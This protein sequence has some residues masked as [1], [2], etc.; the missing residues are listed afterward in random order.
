MPSASMSLATVTVN[1]TPSASSGNYEGRHLSVAPQSPRVTFQCDPGADRGAEHAFDD[2]FGCEMKLNVA[3]RV[4]VLEQEPELGST[5]RSRRQ[6]PWFLQENEISDTRYRKA[7][8]SWK[9]LF[10]RGLGKNRW[11]S[12]AP[13]PVLPR[14]ASMYLARTCLVPVSYLPCGSRFHMGGT[15]QAPRQVH[16]GYTVE[17]S[18]QYGGSVSVPPFARPRGRPASLLQPIRLQGFSAGV[19][20]GTGLQQAPL[21]GAGTACPGTVGLELQDKLSPPRP[22]EPLHW[23][24][25]QPWNGKLL[26]RNDLWHISRSSCFPPEPKVVGFDPRLA[27]HLIPEL[28]HETEIA[29]AVV[30]RA[31]SAQGIGGAVSVSTRKWRMSLRSPKE[32][33]KLGYRLPV[34]LYVPLPGC[35]SNLLSRLDLRPRSTGGHRHRAGAPIHCP[36]RRASAAW[37]RRRS[38]LRSV[39]RQRWVVPAGAL[40]APGDARPAT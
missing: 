38:G 6:N 22:G 28:E 34:T 29:V 10:C 14:C 33:V 15:R 26:A 4:R 31:G 21:S 12:Q 36:G 23:S 19:L 16:H 2:V 27:Y 17:A 1:V 7:V 37:T 24:L 32:P 8:R 35:W 30:V 20:K 13:R 39:R 40:Q 5:S 25:M 3:G 9:P 18:Q 11:G